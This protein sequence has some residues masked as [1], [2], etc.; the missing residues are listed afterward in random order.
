MKNSLLSTMMAFLVVAAGITA[1]VLIPSCLFLAV[2]VLG[3]SNFLI[4][5]FFH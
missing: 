3:N 1:F 2:L 4:T 5:P